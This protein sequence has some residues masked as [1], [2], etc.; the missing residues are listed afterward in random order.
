MSRCTAVCVASLLQSNLYVCRTGNL[1]PRFIIRWFRYVPDEVPASSFWHHCSPGQHLHRYTRATLWNWHCRSPE[2]SYR[3]HEENEEKLVRLAEN[4]CKWNEAQFL[5]RVSTLTRDTDIAI[6]S[7]CLSIYLSV[8][9]SVMIRYSMETA[10]HIVI[11][12]LLHGSQSCFYEFQTSSRNSD[13]VTPF[14]GAIYKWG[15]KISLFM[16]NNSLYLA[17]DIR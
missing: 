7:V 14:G 2:V 1:L 9:L 13:G 6:L 10:E 4:R 11:V 16:T 17:N 3:N 15:I 8:R 12:S 5:S